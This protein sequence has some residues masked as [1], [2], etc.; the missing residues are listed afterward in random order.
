[1]GYS[2]FKLNCGYIPQLGQR[3]GT[4]TKFTGVRQFT[5]QVQ[6]NLMMAHDAII[7]SHVMQAHH[8]NHRQT[9]GCKICTREPRLPVN[10]KLDSTQ[11]KSQK[12]AAQ[13][14]W[15]VQSSRGAY[16]RLYCH[17]GAPT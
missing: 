16:I 15:A 12:T 14:H 8:T 10:P 4:D 5:Q 2:P 3:L 17:V 6:W 13:V 9:T 7:E 11:G 1:M